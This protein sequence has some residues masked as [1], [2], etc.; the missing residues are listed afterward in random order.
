MPNAKK[1]GKKGCET[2]LVDWERGRERVT[3]GLVEGEAHAGVDARLSNQLARRRQPRDGRALVQRDRR[4][5]VG[6]A[7]GPRLAEHFA[8]GLAA[9]VSNRTLGVVA[10]EGAYHLERRVVPKLHLERMRQV[11]RIRCALRDDSHS[12]LEEFD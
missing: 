12:F 9:E 7:R 2:C 5:A 8:K 10:A 4:L 11:E 1:G 6:S 3:G